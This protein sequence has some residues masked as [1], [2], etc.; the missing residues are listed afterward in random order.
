MSKVSPNYIITQPEN[1]DILNSFGIMGNEN[2][3]HKWTVEQRNC[4]STTTYHTTLSDARLLIR[5]EK[6]KCC[7]KHHMNVSIILQDIAGIRESRNTRHCCCF[8]C[9][10]CGRCCRTPR[11]FEVRGIFGS[12]QFIIPK[13]DVLFLQYEISVKAANHKLISH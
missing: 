10:C 13:E 1:D 11:L 3:L 9:T 2:F 5:T 6:R 12:H 8:L 7:M 4:G